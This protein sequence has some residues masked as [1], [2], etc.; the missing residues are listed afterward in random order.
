MAYNYFYIMLL[1]FYLL[2]WVGMSLKNKDTLSQKFLN[3]TI[4]HI[5]CKSF[6]KTLKLISYNYANFSCGND[7]LD[8]FIHLTP[9]TKF[10]F[11]S[12]L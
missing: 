5:N 8:K 11:F 6:F 4:V 3:V 9:Q 1:F 2:F 7:S 10:N 12:N